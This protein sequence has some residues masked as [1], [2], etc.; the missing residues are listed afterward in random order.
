MVL[1]ALHYQPRIAPSGPWRD[2]VIH[3]GCCGCERASAGAVQVGIPF[4]WI[5][6]DAMFGLGS[7]SGEVQVEAAI[8]RAGPVERPE[9][10]SLRSP[11]TSREAPRTGSQ[12]GLLL[13]T[14]LPQRPPMTSP[15]RVRIEGDA[16]T[17]AA[18]CPDVWHA[19]VCCA[20]AHVAWSMMRFTLRRSR[21]SSRA[22]AR[23]L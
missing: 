21:L 16:R 22:M 18:A 13:F 5:L 3:V 23:W 7:P 11:D 14:D 10:P 20:C 12:G 15:P 4:L 1:M 2:D 8:E 19:A 6:L 9:D 17:R